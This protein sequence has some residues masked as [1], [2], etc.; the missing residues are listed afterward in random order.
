VE[1]IPWVAV[2][3]LEEDHPNEAIIV[4]VVVVV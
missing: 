1:I 3:H 2:H 4:G